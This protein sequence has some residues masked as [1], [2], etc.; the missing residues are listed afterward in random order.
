VELLFL[1]V[2]LVSV[3]IINVDPVCITIIES[4]VERTV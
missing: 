2:F 1:V 3:T 4:T